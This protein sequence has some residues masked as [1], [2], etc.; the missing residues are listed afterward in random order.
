MKNLLL[1]SLSISLAGCDAAPAGPTV[2]P[3]ASPAAPKKSPA[4]PRPAPPP[5]VAVSADAFSDVATA[6]DALNKARAANN[7]DEY[8]KAQAWLVMQG[9]AA[10]PP[11]GELLK[12]DSA[13][14]GLRI[15]ACRILGQLG[16]SAAPVLIEHLHSNTQN[17]RSECFKAL[18]AIKPTDA[19]T[20]QTL[21]D[22]LNQ[23]EDVPTQVLAIQSLAQI[24]EPANAVV[25]KLL[26]ILNSD[27]HATL[28]DAAK[29]ALKKI[30]PRHTFQD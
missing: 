19:K 5:V 21:I 11:L 1:L 29:Q 7:T 8:L 10:V 26:E 28:R 23:A 3:S 12:D 18:G 6:L 16:P 9:P 15:L 24:G 13:D 4:A 20:V 30:N 14:L 27:S 25:P 17:V 22:E 2:T